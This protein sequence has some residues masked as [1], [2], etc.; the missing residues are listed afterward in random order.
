VKQS[1]AVSLAQLAFPLPETWNKFPFR[2]HPFRPVDPVSF[3]GRFQQVPK[4]VGQERTCPVLGKPSIYD[5]L[6]VGSTLTI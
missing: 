3:L 4:L 2:N 6:L 5:F 1:D